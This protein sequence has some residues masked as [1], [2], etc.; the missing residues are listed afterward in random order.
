MTDTPPGPMRWRLRALAAVGGAVAAL[1][2]PPFDLWP[3]LFPALAM[4][5]G[6]VAMAPTGREAAWRG[7][8]G[9]AGWFAVAMHWIVQPFFVEPEVFGWMAPFAL[10][11]MAGGLAL[12]WA[13]A[14]WGAGRMTAPGARRALVF[15]GAVV[16]LE[17]ARGRVFSG[18]PWAQPGHGLIGTEALA[19]AAFGGPMG[20]TLVVLALAGASAALVC[21]RRGALAAVP[22]GVGVALGVAPITPDPSILPDDAPLVRIIQINAPQDQKWDPEWIPVFFDRALELTGAPGSPDLIVWPE[23]SLPELIGRSERS[24]AE[25]ADVAGAATTLI[26]GQRYAGFEPRN[27]LA[28]REPG[29]RISSVYDKHHLVPFGE[30]M[31]TRG[32]ADRL[33]FSA[34]AQ[35]LSGGYWPGE[36]PGVIDLGPLGRA[37]PMICYEAIFPHYIRQVERPDF[38]VNITNDAWFGSFAMPYQHL[39][40][41]QLRAAEQGLPVIRA[42]NTG[43]SAMIDGRGQVVEALPMDTAGYIDVRLPP[44]RGVTLYARTGDL[45]ALILAFFVTFAGVFLDRRLRGH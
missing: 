33:G 18:L 3:L 4:V 45:P 24:R 39:A 6:L 38:M 44:P 31:P 21:A 29:G 25:I 26:G 40:L 20:L 10:I 41:S 42:A 23:T 13:V 1:A 30:Y 19:L 32:L 16:L 12:F 14:A 22:V 17:A 5:I 11:L 15:A 27:V 36:G 28:V 8:F 34:I 2:L 7:W 35:Q 43:I 37:F 9:G